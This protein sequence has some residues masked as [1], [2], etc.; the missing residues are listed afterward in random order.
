MK[1]NHLATLFGLYACVTISLP[2]SKKLQFHEEKERKIE[3]ERKKERKRER[4][5]KK[6][7]RRDVDADTEQK[8]ML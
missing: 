5:R 4:E 8:S 6:E 3:K 1:F 2:L 7:R